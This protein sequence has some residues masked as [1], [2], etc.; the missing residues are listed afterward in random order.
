MRHELEEVPVY[1]ALQRLPTMAGLPQD[2]FLLIALIMVCMAIASRLDPMILIGCGA[3]YLLL[4][5]L[6]RRLFAKEPY[7]MDIVPRAMRYSARYPR[8]G[9]ECSAMWRDRVMSN[10]QA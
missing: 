1:T 10:T 6:L 9:R 3:V 2:A 4:L 8:Q 7:L 5:P